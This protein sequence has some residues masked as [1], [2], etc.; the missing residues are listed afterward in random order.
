MC[1]D[2][3]RFFL[4]FFDL[5]IL[6][7]LT[8]AATQIFN[9]PTISG[10]RPTFS[11][12]VLKYFCVALFQGPGPRNATRLHFSH[13]RKLQ[14]DCTFFSHVGPHLLP[15]VG[16]SDLNFCRR[17][18]LLWIHSW[19]GFSMLLREGYGPPFIFLIHFRLWTRPT[20]MKTNSRH[21]S[22][23]GSRYHIRRQ[24]ESQALYLTFR[25]PGCLYC[26]FEDGR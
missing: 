26:L 13:G 8:S 23:F 1:Y 20:R 12:V 6:V 18:D 10:L 19:P 22:H 11:K 7:F 16:S 5:F 15:H 14:H 9:L 21:R 3:L 2:P 24:C 17:S 4:R 25:P